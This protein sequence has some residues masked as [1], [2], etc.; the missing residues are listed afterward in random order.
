MQTVSS[1]VISCRCHF[2]HRPA[3]AT[4][5]GT[6]VGPELAEGD[7]P[8]SLHRSFRAIYSLSS[9]VIHNITNDTMSAADTPTSNDEPQKKKPKRTYRA[10]YPCRSVRPLTA[11]DFL[12]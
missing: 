10:C 5:L 9:L 4:V 3:N 6:G 11:V 7:R 8:T 12:S 2:S 1:E